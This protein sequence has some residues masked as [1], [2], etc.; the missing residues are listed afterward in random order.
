[1]TEALWALD[2]TVLAEG[3]RTGAY[4]CEE[5]VTSAV[6]RMRA[7]NPELNAVVHDVGDEAIAAAQAADR[8]P[9]GQRRGELY[10]VPITIKVNVDVEGQATTNGLPALTNNIAPGDSAVVANVKQAGAII[11]GRTNTPELSMRLTT[12]N[13]LHGRTLNPWHPDA[14]PGGSSGGAGSA[15]AAGFGPLHHGN[16]I[17][18]SLRLPAFCNGVATIKPTQ[19]RVPGFSPSSTAER[20]VLSQL[21]SSQGVICRSVADVRLGTRVMAEADPRDPW[22]VAVPFDGPPVDGPVTV[23]VTRNAHGYPIH[24]GII[25]QID[26][27][28]GALADAGYR[29]IETEPPPITEAYAGWWSTGITEIKLTLD[30]TAR[31]HGSAELQQVFDSYY[32]MGELLDL[33][34]YRAGFSERTRMMR[35]WSVFT[36]AHP[37]VLTPFLMRPT[38]AWDADAHGFDSVADLFMSSMYSCGLNFLGF[39]A[40]VLPTGLVDNLP[41]GIQLVGRRFREDLV[42][43]AMQSIEDRLGRLTPLEKR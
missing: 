41:A 17:G 43:D 42:L 37:I 21:M 10:G 29:V 1:M 40:G 20:G 24:P 13:P 16:D 26:R 22:Q 12:S 9:A 8:V 3:I 30:A 15:C 33:A 32:A 36:D 38:Y 2:A 14:S 6:G 4:T 27:A 25:E 7:M 23:A 39:P 18:G 19:G 11:I 34:G 31:Q 35:D 5:V 28:A